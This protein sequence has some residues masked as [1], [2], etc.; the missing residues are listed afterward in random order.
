MDAF[1]QASQLPQNIPTN[2]NAAE[3]DNLE[4]VS[5]SCLLDAGRHLG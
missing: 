1:D 2:F 3:A 4:D 5:I